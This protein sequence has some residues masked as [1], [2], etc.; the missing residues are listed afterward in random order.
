MMFLAA[1][2]FVSD[3]RA[4]FAEGIPEPDRWER[5]RELLKQL[6]AD[7]AVK[8]AAKDWPITGFNPKTDRVQNLL[9]Y[10]DP[11]YGFVI[12]GL[13][14]NAGGTAMV[15]DH[16]PA[17]TIYGV[18]AGE[19]RIVHFDAKQAEDETFAIGESRAEI[20]RP[21]D[22]DVVQPWLIHSEYAQD[23][24]SIA[25]IVRSQRSG[26]FEQYRYL[27]DGSRVVFGGPEQVPYKLG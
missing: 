9:F 21:G 25:V 15:H 16:G 20:C 22:V 17:W 6:I 5:C 12:N 18:L 19:E 26:T 10:E 24:K 13:I 7:P 2:K 3:M 8:E 14:K 23:E 4:V 27:D 11:D 1:E